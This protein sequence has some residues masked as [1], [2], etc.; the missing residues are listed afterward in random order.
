[1]N[2]FTGVEHFTD[3]INKWNNKIYKSSLIDFDYIIWKKK[4]KY[5]KK[6][7]FNSNHIQFGWQIKLK[8]VI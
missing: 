3:N 1:M 4:K 5:L 2:S 7:Y 6:I 8:K